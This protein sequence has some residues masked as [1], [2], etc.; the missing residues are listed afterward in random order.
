MKLN[1][2]AGNIISKEIH[3]VGIIALGSQR[4]NHGAALP[5]DTDTKIA[6]LVALESCFRTGAHFIGV[7]TKAAEYEFIN[8]GIH[9]PPEDVIKE[10]LSIISN[11]RGI[12]IDRIIIVNGHGGNKI[13]EE[14]LYRLEKDLDVK[15]IFNNAIVEIEGAHGGSGEA[16]LGNVIGILDES[17]LEEHSD[18]EK[19]PEVG[20]VGMKNAREKSRGIDS[21][22]RE[23]EEAGIIIDKEAGKR[24][25]KACTARVIKDI[26]S[27]I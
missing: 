7:A 16:S 2:D 15:I 1:L 14:D 11:A 5:I 26:K 10:L 6:S 3:K 25:L 22:A 8:H 27:V 21:L 19:Y 18:F 17:R 23:T 13:I 9:D 24:L 4:E 20:F 12:G